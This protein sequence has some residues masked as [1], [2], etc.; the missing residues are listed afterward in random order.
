MVLFKGRHVMQAAMARHE[1]PSAQD[2]VTKCAAKVGARRGG[3]RIVTQLGEV[4]DGFGR[5]WWDGSDGF[6]EFIA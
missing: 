4:G 6:D 2:R 1:I 5:F 3:L